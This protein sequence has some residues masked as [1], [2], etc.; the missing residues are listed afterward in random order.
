MMK[1]NFEPINAASRRAFLKQSAVVSLGFLF[2]SKCSSDVKNVEE[3]INIEMLTDPNKY[4]D[5]PKD[6]SYK[7]IS[8][9]GK[10]MSD[11]FMVPGRAD[12]MGAF[13]GP[14]GKVIIVRNHE[15]TTK[16]TG[17]KPKDLTNQTPLL[18]FLKFLLGR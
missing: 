1:N 4:M 13:E 2:L 6:F 10:V 8:K 17:V 14:D 12:G 7:I 5:L 3:A 16:F 9:A 11:G 18:S 15:N